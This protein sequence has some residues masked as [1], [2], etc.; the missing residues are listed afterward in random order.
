MRAV[1][2][3]LF[4]L[5]AVISLASAQRDNGYTD[6]V[7]WDENSLFINGERVYIYSGEFHYARLPVP[8]LW[9]D[10]IQN[11]Y[12]F[13]SYHSP[14]KGVFDF[15][16]PGKDIQ[17]LFDM[18]KEEGV[19]IIARPG[20]YCNAETSA[21]GYGLYLTDG[22]G[23]DIRTNDET[24][25]AQW[26]AWVDAVMPIIARNQI[27][28]GG[29]VILVQVENE[30]TESRHVADDP[31]VLY[32]EQLK[33]AFRDHGIVVPFTSNEKGMRGQSWSVDY[34]DVGGA[35]D[36][37]GL[38][39]YAGGLSCSNIDTGFTVLRTYYQ[40][41]QNYSFTQ[42]E[43][44]PEFKA[45][46]FQPWGGY[47]FDEC[48]SEHDTAYPDVFY[49]NNIAQR[50]TLQN[51]YMTYGGTNWGHLAAPVVYTSYDYG[52]PLRETR[53]VWDKFKHIKLIS[54][55]TRVSDGLLNTRMESNGT[56]NAVND[57]AIFTWVLRNPETE[58]RFYFTQHDNSRSRANT[59]FSLDVATSAGA[60]TIP[61]LD[62]Q[63]R[64][65]RIVVTD[66]PVGDYTLLY[67]SAEVLTYGL[68]DVPVLVFYLNEG[69]VGEL[70]FKGSDLQTANFTTHGATTDFAASAAGN[71]TSAA[72]KYTQTKGATVVKFARGPVL[73][74]LERWAAYTFFAPATTS[75]PH[76]A[77]DEQVFV[78][79]PYLVRS[80]SISGSTVSLSGDHLNATSIDV[81]AGGSDAASA[82]DTISWNG[83]ALA[84]TRSA[85][86]SLQAS[87]PG[88]VDRAVPL[89]ALAGWKVADGLPEA[90]AAYD[91]S[92]WAVAN[93]TTTLSPVAP[94]TLPVLYG[95]DYGFYAGALIYRGHFD[96]DD[97]GVT[98]ANVT[99]Q[100]GAAAGWSA[101]LNGALVGG[102]PGNASLVST[103]AVLDF[104]GAG[105]NATS[106]LAA[107]GNVLTVVT[108]YT[109]H[110]QDSQG[111]YGPLNPRGIIAA[112]LLGDGTATNATAPSFK[113]WKLQ[114]NAGGGAG[115]VDPVRGPLNE[116]GLHGERL[117]WHLPGFDASA[118]D[119]GDPREGFG[120]AGIRWY[121]TEFELDV[122]EDLDAPIGLELGMPEGTVARVQVFVNGY[123]YG[124]Y[125]P[126][127]GPQTKFPFPPG[128]LNNRGSNTLSLS[129]W[130]QSEDGAAFDKVE[131]VLYG[132]YQSDFG[133]SRDWS[134]LQPGWSED[135]LQYA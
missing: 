35:V 78:L 22:S 92:R 47:F 18:A 135:R 106:S 52:A 124:K 132:K 10:V 101:W 46:W 107:E 20:P 70:A 116:G 58:A 16:S 102:H 31:L 27:T 59:A 4:L 122:D 94:A 25:H 57:T 76:V 84:T 39:S 115:Y 23:G 43:Y 129:V 121:T 7:Q 45:G 111:P 134:D 95:S 29:P 37:Y 100:G 103:S 53:E 125:L 26:L 54:L 48:V 87:L 14:S 44:T 80:A 67:S 21:G 34:Q 79:G 69:Q 56:G 75:D 68:F 82:V 77:P 6:V 62:L 15:E 118:W 19:Y 91:D 1:A 51:M 66:Y 109:G 3:L 5:G 24:Y 88:I 105:G 8:E 50:M 119:D 130:A 65:S 32:M 93:K 36:I 11:V 30:L 98:G 131:L 63:G 99:V 85:Y 86:G 40:W 28:E 110:D 81:Y 60:I 133:F 17:K 72:F 71:G 9:R 112:S 123:Q 61:S 74:L 90:A 108:D 49:K 120:G 113:Q 12:F 104:A 89:P 117:G 38:D 2:I 64:Q 96:N 73:Y 33:Q 55:F 42:P 126:H 41:F 114:G 13:W 97:G 83:V 127:I 128:V